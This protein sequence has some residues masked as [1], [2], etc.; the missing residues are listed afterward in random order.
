MSAN[1]FDDLPPLGSV[2]PTVGAN[3]FDDI[4]PPVVPTRKAQPET[5]WGA[6]IAHAIPHT[7]GL[8]GRAVSDAAFA[9]PNMA[10]DFGVG[11][12]NFYG[13]ATGGQSDFEYPS[14]MYRRG[15]DQL[16]KPEN[17]AESIESALAPI[18]IG[19]GATRLPAAASTILGGAAPT[20]AAAPMFDAAGNAMA[21]APN[22]M[23]GAQTRAQ[24]LANTLRK[25]QDLGLVVPRATTNPTT[26]NRLVEMLGGKVGTAQESAV[27]N[28]AAAN[29]VA[30]RYVGLNEDTPITVDAL[31]AIR[32]EAG[33]AYEPLRKLGAVAPDQQLR[34]EMIA[35]RDRIGGVESDFPGS[36]PS[37]LSA[38]INSILGTA[39][40]TK[41]VAS[42]GNTPAP[43]ISAPARAPTVPAPGPRN[44][45]VLDPLTLTP[46]TS[47]IGPN[48]MPIPM[49]T[50]AP[51]AGPRGPN[52]SI[53]LD[54]LTLAERPP[55]PGNPFGGAVAG[56]A[57]NGAT[58]SS[59]GS[60][61]AM[62]PLTM[63]PATRTFDASNMVTKIKNLRDAADVAGRGGD[64]GLAAGYKQIADALEN[65]IDRAAQAR[66]VAGDK[67]IDP[68]VVNNFREGRKLIAKTYTVQDA[69][70]PAS[71]DVSLQVL[72]RM[73]KAGDPMEGELGQLGDFGASFEKASQP[74]AKIGSA[75]VN[76][77]EGG[78]TGMMAAALGTLGGH[79]HGTLGMIGGV[80]V[81]MGLPFARRGAVNWA[82][83]PGQSAAIPKAASALNDL[84]P[85]RAKAAL[86]AQMLKQRSDQSEP[87]TAQ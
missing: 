1:A 69:L 15:A 11:L 39:K 44:G 2:V 55:P 36:A 27:R 7:V 29:R 77:L 31:N 76:H 18:V 30:A 50:P 10:G 38:E 86:L 4:T 8:A 17:K 49:R 80:G 26:T 60:A 73:R 24:M 56:P 71:N 16:V 57:S 74:P 63:N 41:P 87:A 68:N 21:Q 82:L 33:A 79:E 62:D 83:G 37:P 52:G 45:T 12:R 6:Q 43:A 75:G 59:A 66:I 48:G 78:L 40:S 28:Q 19:A 35:A 85:T 34:D 61:V 5:D 58:R 9:L 67:S 70:N 13:K 72:G 54:P 64:K 20:T 51:A 84:G 42:V 22:S 14:D 3:A 46:Q 65:Q 25:S 32:K 47:T 23:T 81:G 53:S